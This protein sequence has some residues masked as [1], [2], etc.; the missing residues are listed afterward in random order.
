VLEQPLDL[1]SQSS[2]LDDYRRKVFAGGGRRA[3]AVRFPS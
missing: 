1:R 2:H 3:D